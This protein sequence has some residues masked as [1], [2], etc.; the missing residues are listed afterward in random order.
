[1]VD[2]RS[3]IYLIIPTNA[4]TFKPV[5]SRP[6]VASVANNARP[7]EPGLS[8]KLPDT[9]TKQSEDPSEHPSEGLAVLSV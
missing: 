8:L 6:S 3:P 7:A 5:Y 1:M 2:P 9:G 4:L